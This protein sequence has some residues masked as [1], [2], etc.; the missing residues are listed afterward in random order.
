MLDTTTGN[1]LFESLVEIL[2]RLTDGA[3]PVIGKKAVAFFWMECTECQTEHP[4]INEELDSPSDAE[5]ALPK[6]TA[7]KPEA[8]KA[9]IPLENS[10]SSIEDEVSSSTSSEELP[11]FAPSP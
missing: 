7:N 5:A 2:D 11:V 6:F 1:D 8:V 3:P 4:D 9:S 10:S